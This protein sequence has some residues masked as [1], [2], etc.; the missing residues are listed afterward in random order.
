MVALKTDPRKPNLTSQPMFQENII[1]DKLSAALQAYPTLPA[2][3]QKRL[4]DHIDSIVKPEKR[5]KERQ[6]GSGDTTNHGRKWI[7]LEEDL[8]RSSVAS[9]DSVAETAHKLDRKSD[10]VA[11]RGFSLRV[12]KFEMDGDDNLVVTNGA[13]PPGTY[14]SPDMYRRVASALKHHTVEQAASLFKSSE[15]T[16]DLHLG[17][18]YP[19]LGVAPA[20]DSGSDFEE[21]CEFLQARLKGRV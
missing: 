9:G 3:I 19:Q 17:R 1:K 4:R 5:S 12:L 16:I 15:A 10:A 7:P 11:A 21:S 8:L 18:F 14:W 20:S 6:Y 13:E 2:P